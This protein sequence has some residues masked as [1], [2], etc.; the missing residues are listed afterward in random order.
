MNRFRKDLGKVFLPVMEPE[1]W[2][3]FWHAKT[4]KLG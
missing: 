3:G 1:D 2:L 4:K